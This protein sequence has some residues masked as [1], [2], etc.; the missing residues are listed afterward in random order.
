M[1][2]RDYPGL[3][4][5]HPGD[6]RRIGLVTVG[7]AIVTLDPGT[8]RFR[9]LTHLLDDEVTGVLAAD[10]SCTSAETRFTAKPRVAG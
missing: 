5:A 3:H 2:S 4:I 7:L 6:G 1:K 10:L 8:Q 9:Q